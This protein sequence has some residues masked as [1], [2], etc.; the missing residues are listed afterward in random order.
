MQE[1]KTMKDALQRIAVMERELKH[2]KESKERMY[3]QVLD[4]LEENR[5][6]KKQLCG[7]PQ[8]TIDDLEAQLKEN[9]L[10]EMVIALNKILDETVLPDCNHKRAR[11]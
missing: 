3:Q 4:G 9:V 8:S 6:L 2:E 7:Q 11:R 5:R 1:P 10:Q